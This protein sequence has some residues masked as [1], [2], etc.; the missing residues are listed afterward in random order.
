[1]DSGKKKKIIIGC[2][3]GSCLLLGAGLF[4]LMKRSGEMEDTTE[5]AIEIA[6]PEAQ[7]E[8]VE[9]KIS[10]AT[11]EAIEEPKKE[12]IHAPEP[13]ISDDG[14]NCYTL[15]WDAQECDGYVVELKKDSD[16]ETVAELSAEYTKEKKSDDVTYETGRLDPFSTYTFRVTAKDGRESLESEELNIETRESALYATV[17]TTRDMAVFKNASGNEQ[18]TTAPTLSAYSV[19]GEENGRFLVKTDE[20]EGYIDS[21][22]CMINLPDYIGGL[23]R[24]D[25]TNSYSSIYCAHNY[26]IPSV[27]GTVITGYENVLLDDDTFVVP[28]LYP[29]AKK[30]IVGAENARADGY[31]IK[32][33]DSFRPYVATRYIYDETMKCLDYMVPGYEYSRVN[34]EDYR[35]GASTGTIGLSGLTRYEPQIEYASE[36]DTVGT[37][38]IDP[39]VVTYS[40]SMLSDGYNLGAFL[41]ANGSTHNLGIAMDMTL[42]TIDGEELAM[43]SHM[44]DLSYHSVPGAN[45]ANANLLKNYM[46]PAGFGMINSEWWHFQDNETRS[47]IRPSSVANGVS[48]E[49]WKKDDTGWRYRLSNGEYYVNCT[50]EIGGVKFSFDKEGYTSD[51]N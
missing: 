32:I 17:W 7:T 41:A 48:V 15:S 3:I 13:E 26:A 51:Y 1:M 42:E 24:Y 44:H 43:Q 28:L 31:V 45:N 22:Y 8:A 38:V 35:A 49:G 23:C 30:L 2:I 40:R 20:G 4:F 25:I 11:P 21:N 10:E 19:L 27:T 5:S 39:N 29:T 34:V 33:N 14:N 37:E 18:L 16:W 6:T 36:G 12:E 50:E 46:V 47:A 9:E